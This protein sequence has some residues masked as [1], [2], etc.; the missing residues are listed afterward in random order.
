MK[1]EKYIEDLKEIKDLMNKS[2]KFISLSG[3][4]GIGIGVVALIA[5]Y[6]A[7]FKIESLKGV[8]DHDVIVDGLKYLLSLALITLV[9]SLTLGFV[10]TYNKSKRLGQKMWTTQTKILLWNLV[11][12]LFIGGALCLILLSQGRYGSVSSFTLL[13]YGLALINASKYTL[14]EIRGLGII[15]CILGLSGVYFVGHGLLFWAI[16]FG[17]LHI[18]YGILMMIKNK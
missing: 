13:F 2:S 9:L 11:I 8:S 5:S 1:K 7:Y 3:W 10:F 15:N 17:V 16:G 14:S 18:I 12:P 6:F 4:S